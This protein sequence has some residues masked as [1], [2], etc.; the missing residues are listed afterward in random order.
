MTP[1]RPGLIRIPGSQ[2]ALYDEEVESAV[3][4]VHTRPYL[5]RLWADV[6]LL[7]D[8]ART[9]APGDLTV[10]VT[11][12]LVVVAHGCIQIAGNLIQEA[13]EKGS[14]PE[15]RAQIRHAMGTLRFWCA[16]AEHVEAE[17]GTALP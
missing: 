5:H 10:P 12:G 13:T 8:Q 6:D 7:R 16:V 2:R 4:H 9:A 11:G 3:D 1:S 17:T 14:G 15:A